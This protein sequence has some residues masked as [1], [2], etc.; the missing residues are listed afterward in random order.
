MAGHAGGL[1]AAAAEETRSAWSS[2]GEHIA[3]ESDRSGY[4]NIHVMRAS[5]SDVR[6]VTHSDR[7]LTLSG[8]GADNASVLVDASREGDVYRSTRPYRV[9]LEGGPI[10]RLHDAFGSMP[11]ENTDGLIVFDRGGASWT[12]RHYRGADSRDVWLHD[13]NDGTFTQ[14]TSW[15]GNDGKARFLGNDQVLFLSDRDLD[16][17]NIW[18]QRV[19]ENRARRLTNF[20]GRDVHDFDVSADGSRIVMTVWD[21]L[22]VLDQRA[23]VSSIR[24]LTITAADDELDET[25]LKSMRSEV[26]EAEL[27]PDGEVMAYVAWGD[28]FVRNVKDNSPTRQ[29][30]RGEARERDL[31]WSPDGVTLYFVSDEDGTNSIYTAT[32]ATTRSEIRDAFEEAT[33]PEVTEEEESPNEDALSDAAEDADAADTTGEEGDEADTDEADAEEKDEAKKDETH[34]GDRWHDAVRFDV[35]PIVASAFNDRGPTPSPDGET[36]AFRRTR[37]DLMLLDLD[38]GDVSTF[39][40]SW[41]TWGSWAWSPDSRHIAYADLDENFNSEVFIGRADGT[42]EHVNISMHP[43]NDS[44]PR[45]SADGRILA[46]ISDRINDENDVWMVYLDRDL[47]AMTDLELA[48]YYEDAAKAAKK[49][50]PLEPKSED[51][52]AK[53]D[54]ATDDESDED[55]DESPELSLGDAYLRLRRVTSFPRDEGNLM[56]APGGDKYIFSAAGGAA[57]DG[58][59]F[60]V[61]WD[62]SDAKR[63]G[64]GASIQHVTLDGGH[65]VIVRGGRAAT[66]KIDGGKTE[67]IDLSA[68]VN[69]DLESQSSQMFREAA[70]ELGMTFYHP[71]MKGLDWEGLTE[72]YH[73]LA[74]RSRTPG[75][76][77]YVANRFIGELNASHLGVR[78]PTPANPN[79][80]SSGRL[81]IDAS[82]R[83]GGGF[84]VDRVLE[85]GPAEA[86]SMRLHEGDVITAIDFEPLDEGATIDEL[87]TGRTGDEVVVTVERT[88]DDGNTT[89]L[90]LLMTPVGYGTEVRLRY[91]DWQR[92]NARLVDEWSDGRIGYLHIRSM[93]S[94][95]LIEFERDLY[96]AAHGKDG[97][98]I[99]V[100]NNGGGW[101]TD[102]ILASIMVTPHA[103]TIPRGDDSGILTGYPQDRLFI[104]RYTQPVNMLC[105]E[106]SFSNAEIISHAFKTLGRGTLVGQE[107]YGAVISTG[108]FTLI[109]GTWVRRPFRG[110]FLPDG[111][112][113][114]NNGAVPDI[115]VPQSPDDEVAE[116]PHGYDAQLKAAVV[117]L[118]KRVD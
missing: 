25:E 66:V 92:H 90:D 110:W 51:D 9:S 37:G 28:V 20:D 98:L 36:L 75:E 111:T 103:Y 70:R 43:D 76:F 115:I 89:E 18:G 15:P 106:K 84:I 23:P 72:Q 81:G 82:P 64:S 11:N 71:T 6:Q 39:K 46:F 58:G 96:A 1:A 52:D 3:F 8:F 65:I 60:T 4:R 77:A 86:G 56:L 10:E 5:G 68:R 16:T 118:L 33:T 17:V 31:A 94:P 32:V 40:E 7:S 88:L 19:G 57:G 41:N 79:R 105:N 21:T 91:D 93:G 55:I 112:D 67:F 83:D 117:D 74:R 87:L 113:M 47:E 116:S 108:G 107:T 42:G 14:V 53:D 109:D 13:T 35:E 29:V 63:L 48:A 95:S 114:E 80:Q 78:P 24:P 38:S 61:K 100:R 101:T 73:E 27:S 12:R 44:Q 34:P 97:L 104:Q 99:D 62:G 54:E 30:T 2:D 59:I 102:R 85:Y 49:R 50:K 26:S 22:Y 45:W 69:V